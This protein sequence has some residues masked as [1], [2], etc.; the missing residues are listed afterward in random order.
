[1]RLDKWLAHAGLGTRNDVKALIRQGRVRVN[2][3]VIRQ[4]DVHVNVDHDCVICDDEAVRAPTRLVLMM[5]KPVGVVS[6]RKDT[7]NRTVIDC[8]PKPMQ[9]RDLHIAGRLDK[10]ASGLLI[11]TTDTALVHDIIAPKK[12]VYKTYDVVVDGRLP[13]REVFSKPRELKDGK[14]RPYTPHPPR[15]VRWEESA[16]RVAVREG[17]FHQVKRMF[18]AA[19]AEVI[20]LKRVAI[21]NLE[22]GDLP[23]GAVR[24]LVSQDIEALL[25]SDKED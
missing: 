25:M 24:E 15:I 5:H 17:K 10:D 4:P 21:G 2:D 14:N 19:G 13:S 12:H 6:A 7:W 8:L 22:L 16:A 23:E 9:R 1:M 18:K 3:T 11:L 20:A